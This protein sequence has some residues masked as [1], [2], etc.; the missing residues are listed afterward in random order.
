MESNR[1]KK[2]LAILLAVLFLVTM[3]VTIVSALNPQ[4]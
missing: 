2:T 3:T 4:P 1:L